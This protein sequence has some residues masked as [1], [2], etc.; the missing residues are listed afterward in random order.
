[1]KRFLACLFILFLVLSCEVG[2]GEELDLEAPELTITSPAPLSLVNRKFEIRGS[3]TDNRRV[4]KV[5]ITDKNTNKVYANANVQ[6][7]E[8]FAQL[9]MQE[10]E[11]SLIITAHDAAGNSSTKSVKTMTLLVDE[12]APEG[13]SWYVD[14]GNGIQTSL[15]SK[16]ELESLD[17]ED[18]INIDIP[19]N[20]E[21]TIY[22]SFY[23]AMSISKISLIL[24]EDGQEFIRKTVAA[25]SVESRTEEFSI[26]APEF[27]FTHDE[28]VEKK[29]SLASGK[30]YLKVSYQSS[31]EHGNITKDADGNPCFYDVG[32]IL[33]Y[34]ESDAPVVQVKNV[35][36]NILTEN[37]GSAISINLFDD[38]YLDEVYFT[39]EPE[40]TVID[41]NNF[42]SIKDSFKYKNLG[43]ENTRIFYSQIE[44]K[45]TINPGSY[46][47][48]AYAK[49]KKSSGAKKILKT[50]KVNI[51]DSSVP[52]IIV[53]S[54]TENTVPDIVN[55][56]IFK[57][58]GFC[59][60]TSGSREIKIAYIPSTDEYDNATKKENRAKAIF[61]GATLEGEELLKSY[62]FPIEKTKDGTW[63]KEEFEFEFNVVDEFTSERN[64]AK[65]FEIMAIDNE[66]HKVYKQFN[67]SGD[68]S[69]PDIEIKEPIDNMIVY[70]Y[71]NEDIVLKFRATKNSGLGIDPNGYK[72]IRN[73]TSEVYSIE[74]G[75]LEFVD[76]NT[77][78]QTTIKKELLEEW[79]EEQSDTQPVFTFFAKDLLNNEFSLQ[80]TVVLSKLPALENITTEK[81]NGKYC[82]GQ[83]LP[84]QVKFTDSVK[85][86]GNPILKLKFSEDGEEKDAIY[87]TGSGTDTL[88]FEYQV[89]SGDQSDMLRSSRI[90]LN[91][92]RIDTGTIGTGAA[93]IEIKDGSHLQD[94]KSGIVIDGISPSI[95]KIYYSLSNVNSYNNSYYLNLDK[96]FSVTVEFSEK[97]FV[98]GSPVL[99]LKVN[100]SSGT[101]DLKL[102]FQSLKNELVVFNHKVADTSSEGIVQIKENA[103]FNASDIELIKD[104]AGNSI[105]LSNSDVSNLNQYLEGSSFVE[106]TLTIDK[107]S[108]LNAPSINVTEGVY[109]NSQSLE[110][111]NI[112]PGATSKYSL[113]GGKSWSVYEEAVEI[114]SGDYSICTMQIDIAGNESAK[115]EIVN[116][117]IND[118]FPMISMINIRNPDGK[119]KK[120][121]KISL[122]VYLSDYIMSVPENSANI[123][124]KNCQGT[125]QKQINVTPF[126]SQTKEL[127][128]EYVI[129]E[130]DS[131]NGVMVEA[132]ELTSSLK[133]KYGNIPSD[134]TRDAIAEKL[135]S[136]ECTRQDVVIDAKPPTIVEYTPE[137]NGICSE[138]E[139][140]IVLEFDENIYLESGSITLQRK[141][142]WSIPAIMDGEEFFSVFNALEDDADKQKLMRFNTVA[143]QANVIT[144]GKTGKAVGPYIPTTQGLIKKNDLATPDIKTK[145]VLDFNLG[146][147]EGEA[148]LND[149]TENGTFTASVADIR[150]CFEKVGYH[151]HNEDIR[152]PKVVLS[153][154]NGFETNVV[155]IKFSDEI[156]NG[157]E[158]ELIIPDTCFRDDAGNMFSGLKLES[159]DSEKSYT[160]WSNKVSTP[161]VRVDR[162]SHGW[163]A[164][165][166]D[167]NGNINIITENNENRGNG[168]YPSRSE[169]NTGT[170]ISPSGYA[171]VRIDSQ[172]PDV[173]IYYKEVNQTS[174]TAEQIKTNY[175][176]A[177]GTTR[178]DNHNEIMS[179]IG[180][181]QYATLND[182]FT[183]SNKYEGFII[184][185]DGRI[186]TA[187]KD[188]ITAYAVKDGF[189]NSDNGFEGIFKTVLYFY[190]SSNKPASIEGGTSNGGEPTI[191]NFPVR[192]GSSDMRYAKNAYFN[193]DDNHHV[194][195]SYDIVSRWAVLYMIADHSTDYPASEYGQITY[196]YEYANY[197]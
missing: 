131:Y 95:E 133:D 124:I 1:M 15:K 167:A 74:N 143:G 42:D 186:D 123:T 65:F 53:E 22:G 83:I 18:V 19:Q 97:V 34:P 27:Y 118:T 185:G 8:W 63:V 59:Y 150:E 25:D 52:L 105:V 51:V 91:S 41:E 152:S 80:R 82:T 81:S 20:E 71:R 11:V 30:H 192:D 72:I 21:F 45:Y 3:C 135:N 132:L 160:L 122:K 38:D 103:L 161:V 169:P 162:Y 180:D 94:S 114:Y 7:D 142:N 196:T 154:S 108:P 87:K 102:N 39:I 76:N 128:F 116:I 57:I 92:G 14:R 163:G 90:D 117:S 115:S 166:P 9:N 111:S 174:V 55:G 70:D 12:T 37:I 189:S 85:V 156:Q 29:S 26:Y 4:T 49:E 119:Y 98:S 77:Y 178:Y 172:T 62:T 40:G 182:V 188:Y 99:N 176:N 139:F 179:E 157:I 106:R 56:N 110:L 31:D 88:T 195:V 23:D 126:A 101:R 17:V 148:Q 177:F 73:G 171:R 107:T 78:V 194:W 125:D 159:E 165:I 68:N 193:T 79:A 67:V 149:G 183:S 58:K 153:G 191:S 134:A 64:G 138:D 141:G 75:K 140:T 113:D 5:S 61:D 100:S 170:T 129:E 155:T 6:N 33:W 104:E 137:K 130:G 13:L 175:R 197:Y 168:S 121:E 36:N 60:D 173:D 2:L 84:I 136:E 144:H 54:P 120:G 146:L 96:E 32:Y 86:V 28:L 66:G 127:N 10:G 181:V 158:W 69:K 47:L 147:V 145:Y 50:V 16:E 187:R 184:V 46:I 164:E 43:I 35:E 48:A 93:I 24:S 89:K 44:S 190:D 112:E 109:N 151:I